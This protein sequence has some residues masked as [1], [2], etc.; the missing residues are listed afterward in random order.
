MLREVRLETQTKKGTR[1]SSPATL[2]YSEGRIFFVKSPFALKDEIK[3]MRGSKWHGHDESDGR[4]IWSVEDCQRNRLQLAYLEGEDV[5]AWFDRDMV[6]HDYADSY[7][8]GRCTELMPHQKDLADS[9]LTY[10]YQLWAAEMGVGKTLAA[11]KVIE[12]SGVTHWWWVGPKSSIPNIKREF[13]RWGFS[14][15]GIKIEFLTY[16]GLTDRID[17]W[18]PGDILPQG[19]IFDESSR[20]KGATSQ[21]T[22]AAQRLADMIRDKFGHEGYVILMSGTPSPKSPVDWWA[23]CEIAWPGFLKEGS[24]KALE[25]R[26]AFIVQQEFESGIFPKRVGWKDDENKCCEC[27]KLESH[28]NHHQELVA[29]LDEYHRFAPSLN[30]VAFMYERLKGLVVIKL[31]KDC[32]NLPE[33]RYRKIICKPSASTLRV[34]SVLAEAAPNTMTGLT[35]LREL[36]DGFQYRDVQDGKIACPHCPESKGEVEEWFD[37]SDEDRTFRAID[38][39]DEELVSTSGEALGYL[40]SLRRQPGSSQDRPHHSRGCL[41]QGERAEATARRV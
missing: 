17:E 23:Q 39:L 27:G 22:R 28:E 19:V 24:P 11:Q 40:P 36:S 35:W 13:K 38:M 37:P 1:V 30:E 9:A 4:K 10:H 21:R 8:N 7:L 2:E 3:A 29:D 34:A 32:L 41:P 6:R 18:K 5:F 15:M 16:E 31:K 12:K 33:K 26:M 20:L 25:Q 14:S